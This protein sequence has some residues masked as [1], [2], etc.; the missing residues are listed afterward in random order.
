MP[1]LNMPL[2]QSLSISYCF[3]WATRFALL[4]ACPWLSYSAPLALK[5]DNDIPA[6]KHFLLEFATK[7]SV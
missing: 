1:N 5:A 3:P 7:K 6:K 2:F 4:S